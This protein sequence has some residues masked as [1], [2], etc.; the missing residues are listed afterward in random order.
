[1]EV[2][3]TSRWKNKVLP[4]RVVSMIGTF[5]LM[6]MVFTGFSSIFSFHQA[7]ADSSMNKCT[8]FTVV[9]GEDTTNSLLESKLL[10]N[11]VDTFSHVDAYNKSVTD[12]ASIIPEDD[13]VIVDH[14]IDG[15]IRSFMEGI[16][17]SEDRKVFFSTPVSYN[18]SSSYA[19]T[20]DYTSKIYTYKPQNDNFIIVDYDLF[21]NDKSS[22]ARDG[23]ALN[24]K[25][26]NNKANILLENIIRSENKTRGGILNAS[27]ADS[28]ED[29]TTVVASGVQSVDPN[30]V[31]VSPD[32]PDVVASPDGE[33]NV[34]S[35]DRSPKHVL[36]KIEQTSLMTE[37]VD[38]LAA[39]RWSG[40]EMPAQAVSG[41]ILSSIADTMSTWM[42]N[43][44]MTTIGFFT[45]LGVSMTTAA[46]SSD[47]VSHMLVIADSIFAW[48]TNNNAN[49]GGTSDTRGGVIGSLF[50]AII[51]VTIIT[52]AVRVF[53][54]TSGGAGS[55]NQKFA[56]I[57][58][59]VAKVVSALGILTLMSIQSQKNG[60]MAQERIAENIS[61]SITTP[62]KAVRSIE[63][64]SSWAPG[65]MGWALSAVYWIVDQAVGAAV[66]VASIMLTGPLDGMSNLSK[67]VSVGSGNYNFACDRYI[68]SMHFLFTK[69]AAYANNQD[70]GRLLIALDLLTLPVFTEGFA[71]GYGD[72]TSSAQN[73]W[74]YDAEITSGTSSQE[75]AIIARGAGLYKEA[76]GSGNIMHNDNTQYLVGN[77]FTDTNSNLSGSGA[78]PVFDGHLLRAD[79]EW[80]TTDPEGSETRLNQFYGSGGSGTARNIMSYYFA[81][82]VWA[83]EEDH[84]AL[85]E[86]WRGVRAMGDTGGVDGDA[87]KREDNDDNLMKIKSAEEAL[88]G[89]AIGSAANMLNYTHNVILPKVKEPE[90]TV[91]LNDY[92]CI[93][94]LM[95]PIGHLENEDKYGP[96]ATKDNPRVER[97]NFTPKQG[98]DLA[99]QIGTTMQNMTTNAFVGIALRFFDSEKPNEAAK[100]TK[101]PMNKFGANAFKLDSHGESVGRSPAAQ[102]WVARSGGNQEEVIMKLICILALVLGVAVLMFVINLIG[103]LVNTIFAILFILIPMFLVISIMI[104][105]LRGGRS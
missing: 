43:A 82:C 12:I 41:F 67:D 98:Q 102:Y 37:M 73:S 52:A 71:T 22:F 23:S 32:A 42:A 93:D 104:Y 85:S 56:E 39:K 89:E 30:G 86:E 58:I 91:L 2:Y 99:D 46:F 76:L 84:A 95:F 105:A 101:N 74:C 11:G 14:V 88:N 65:S 69:S 10:R 75:F 90:Y 49:V 80:T 54:P 15:D 7:Y 57:G 28:T 50:G 97:W 60:A 83:P 25:G 19:E 47:L 24:E 63:D 45:S 27:S 81:A 59:S 94:P 66:G 72:D 92:D 1:M 18:G 61:N 4:H 40:I 62:Q 103:F 100:D 34:S 35:Y 48:L 70:A 20:L 26:S 6:L 3:T 64:P 8:S 31:G 77:H 21:S 9:G 51:L 33:P 38:F 55:F 16:Q 29:G 78:L 87:V 44:L 79:G 53:S 68:D 17:G 5:M 36:D 13:C 96:A